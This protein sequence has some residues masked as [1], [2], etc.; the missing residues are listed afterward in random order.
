[1]RKCFCARNKKAHDDGDDDAPDP[2]MGDD[3][4]GRERDGLRSV[5]LLLATGRK[6]KVQKIFAA[7]RR[8]KTLK[9]FRRFAAILTK[10]D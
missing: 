9:K 8:K 10:N 6:K 4:S 7:S 2:E 5:F 1:M 3:P